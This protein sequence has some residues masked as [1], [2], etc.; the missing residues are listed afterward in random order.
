MNKLYKILAIIVL[1]LFIISCTP[2][3][4]QREPQRPQTQKTIPITEQTVKVSPA[5]S[6]LTEK[7]PQKPEE[8]VKEFKI[9]ME[10]FTFTPSTI[11]VNKGDTVK[12]TITSLDVT[13]GVVIPE[14]NINVQAKK[15]ETETVEFIAD[16][17]GTF[18]FYCAVYCGS[19]HSE[20]KGTLI[21]NE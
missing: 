21:V 20:M 9:I 14:F 13:H 1:T 18:T 10:K 8:T 3:R 17:A 16:K 5:T 6:K 11:T 7:S 4:E 15:G 19:G 12:L 2:A